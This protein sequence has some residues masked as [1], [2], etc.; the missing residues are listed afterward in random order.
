MKMLYSLV[1]FFMLLTASAMAGSEIT[2][3]V[4]RVADGDTITL[5]AQGNRQIKVRLYG[6]DCPERSQAY[7]QRARQ[8]TASRVAGQTVRV[9]R[10]DTDRYGRVVGIVDNLDGGSLNQDLLANGL[11]WHYTHYCK[12]AFCREWKQD[13][14]RARQKRLGLWK[15][16]HPMEPW[17]YRRQNRRK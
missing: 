1:L 12:A 15:D 10:M 7:G 17:Q 9:T 11:A 3:K 2:G 13:E 8:F 16:A 4:V 6:I 14:L 5:L